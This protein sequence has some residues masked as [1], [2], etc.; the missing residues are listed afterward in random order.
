MLDPPVKIEDARLV[1]VDDLAGAAYPVDQKFF[2][3]IWF[4]K[5]ILLIRLLLFGGPVEIAA[6]KRLLD[7]AVEVLSV[8]HKPVVLGAVGGGG[9][10][11]AVGLDGFFQ[12]AEDIPFR[13]HF[14]GVVMRKETL[15]HLE[16]VVV[17]CHRDDISGA[18]VCKGFCP[19][20]SVELIGGKQ[21][22]EVLVA[23][24]PVRPIG[25]DMVLILGG[26]LDVHIPRIP[27]VVVGG[28]AVQS[29]V[30]KDAK[31]RLFKPGRHR[32]V[33]EGFPGIPVRAL[34][35]H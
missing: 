14:G 35:D 23:K 18:C 17:L 20:V 21:R 19:E 1:A 27:L 29:P 4:G 13:S 31:L 2:A 7:I 16:S 8:S 34:G 28:N 33:R 22:D 15:V 5:K 9:E 10:G 32:K 26:S 24:I 6:G 30:D 3:G 12:L 11:H 25:F